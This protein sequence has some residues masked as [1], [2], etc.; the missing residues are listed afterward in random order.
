MRGERSGE[1]EG[2]GYPRR[3]AGIDVIDTSGVIH[4]EA[5]RD[6]P[7]NRRCARMQWCAAPCWALPSQRW[8]RVSPY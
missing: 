3:V 4:A 8:A 5:V 7:P 1:P 6:I 2:K